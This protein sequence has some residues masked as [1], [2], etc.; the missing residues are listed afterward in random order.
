MPEVIGEQVDAVRRRLRMLMRRAPDD[1]TIRALLERLK[2]ALA[3]YT[4]DATTWST[5]RESVAESYEALTDFLTADDPAKP[6][7]PVNYAR[8]AFHMGSAL[9][10]LLLALV[11]LSPRG[12][13]WATAGFAAWSWSLEIAR[14][15]S[16]RANALLMKF[17][18]PIAHPT[19]RARVNSATWYMTALFVLGLSGSTV[20]QVTAVAVLGF[21]DPIAGLVGRRFGRVRLVNGRSLEGTLAFVLAA[22]AVAFLVLGIARPSMLFSTRLIVAGVAASSGAVAE[23]LSRRVDDN[24]SIPLVSGLAAFVAFILLGV[25][26]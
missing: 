5:L 14:R 23:L 1:A 17:F 15:V 8:S 20:V 10:C 12:V 3:A 16:T 22:G 24:L 2:V 21:G 7:R 26:L 25:V 11:I 6:A 13:L 18:R 9:V 4:P 19:E